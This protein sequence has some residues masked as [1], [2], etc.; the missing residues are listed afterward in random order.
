[1]VVLTSAPGGAAEILGLHANTL[2]YLMEK[3]G[4]KVGRKTGDI[5][6]DSWGRHQ[7]S[8]PI[9]V[10]TQHVVFLHPRWHATFFGTNGYL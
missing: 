9:F 8:S 10:K 5:T 2:D 7:Y 4:I 6:V 3:L 1:M